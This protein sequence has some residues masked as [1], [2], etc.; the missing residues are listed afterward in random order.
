MSVTVNSGREPGGAEAHQAP[1]E[2]VTEATVI[3][4]SN[5][6]LHVLFFK[7]ET[8]TKKHLRLQKVG[9]RHKHGT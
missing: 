7:D 9:K 2:E 8:G 4:N 1:P 3:T 5:Y 6:K